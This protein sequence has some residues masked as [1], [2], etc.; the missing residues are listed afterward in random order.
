MRV[1]GSHE[2]QVIEHFKVSTVEKIQSDMGP[3]IHVSFTTGEYKRSLCGKCQETSDAQFGDL[4]PQKSDSRTTSPKPNSQT[5]GI[6]TAQSFAATR[7]ACSLEQRHW[8][9]PSTVK[10]GDVSTAPSLPRSRSGNVFNH[11]IYN[12]H[13]SQNLPTYEVSQNK[14]TQASQPPVK[15]TG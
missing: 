3:R 5:S 15:N 2:P 10:G 13:G 4:I 9:R 14:K 12:E 1:L 8:V 6:A 7:R 11:V